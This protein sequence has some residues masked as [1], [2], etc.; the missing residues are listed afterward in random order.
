MNF[1]RRRKEGKPSPGVSPSY[2]LPLPTNPHQ[3]AFITLRG[4]TSANNCLVAHSF[5]EPPRSAVKFLRSFFQKATRVKGQRPLS[6]SADAETPL[7]LKSAGR[8]EFSSQTKRGETLA[9]GFPSYAAHYKR[10]TTQR[11]FPTL[12][13]SF[14]WRYGFGNPSVSLVADSSLCTREPWAG[15]LSQALPPSWGTALALR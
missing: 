8:G 13:G 3:K 6:A 5:V 12:R 1:R 7:C 10:R 9:G 11:L 4:L 2:L 15:A 14:Y